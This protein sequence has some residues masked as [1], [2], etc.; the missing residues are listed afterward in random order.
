MSVYT[1]L[2]L[3]KR[4][5]IAVIMLSNPPA[6]T[7]TQAS[8]RALQRLV[9]DL[10]VD[11]QVYSL[12]LTGEGQRFFSTGADLK[13]FA[14]G[15]KAMARDMARCFGEAFATL[16][17]FRGVSIAAINGYAMGGGLECAM[18]CDVRIA[19]E[20]TV[21]ALPEPKVGILPCG[22]GTQML[23]W[24]IGEG[25]AK[26]MAQPSSCVGNGSMRPRRAASVWC[27][28]SCPRVRRWRKHLTWPPALPSK[29]RSE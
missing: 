12:V 13:L 16:A 14:N 23:S 7:W 11:R 29:A 1:N 20:Y 5:H 21:L 8:L 26:R 22:G 28:R 6:H 10:T 18:A 25:W 24:L 4:G 19:E 17:R 3:K 2:K 27:K 9:S 15:D